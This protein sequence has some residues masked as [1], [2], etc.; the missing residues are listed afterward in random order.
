[1]GERRKTEW[2]AMGP[3]PTTQCRFAKRSQNPLKIN[4]SALHFAKRHSV[5]RSRFGSLAGLTGMSRIWAVG[6]VRAMHFSVRC[7]LRSLSA[8][9]SRAR[10]MPGAPCC[11]RRV[12][13]VLPEAT[14][15]APTVPK[16]NGFCMVLAVSCTRARPGPSSTDVRSFLF[17]SN[18]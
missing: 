6:M 18:D 9:S 11:F 16:T 12:S 1:M 10:V 2:A 5:V 15:L 7:T 8:F 3:P 14:G 17:S 4:G 13:R